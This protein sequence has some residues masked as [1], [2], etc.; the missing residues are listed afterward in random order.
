MSAEA[1]LQRLDHVR[2]RGSGRWSARCPAHDDRG[3]SLS[4][5]ETPDGTT[6]VHCFAGCSVDAIV[7]AAGLDLADL[8]PP[9][10]G[11]PG[12]GAAPRR[13]AFSASDA[14]AALHADLH[15]CCIV[16][17]GAR[18][19]ELPTDDDWRAFMGAAGRCIAISE[20]A[21]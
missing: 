4:I 1:L 17:S 16:L 9:R 15:L 8:F 2:A 21:R 12:S 3:P 20:A 13:R 7:A 14:L 11:A 19:G 10:D 5:K 6:L 18:R